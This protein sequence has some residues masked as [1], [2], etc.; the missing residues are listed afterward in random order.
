VVAAIALIAGLVMLVAGGL[1]PLFGA[2]WEHLV[3]AGGGVVI[4]AA[5]AMLWS[6]WR[7]R[8]LPVPREALLSL[9]ENW[10]WFVA[11]VRS[12]LTLPK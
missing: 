6:V 7:L 10:E 11:Q 4:A 12:R 3:S 5:G 9:M 8:R 1:A 2:R